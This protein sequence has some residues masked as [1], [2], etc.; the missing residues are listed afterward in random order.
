M[1]AGVVCLTGFVIVV[2]HFEECASATFV[3]KMVREISDDHCKTLSFLIMVIP[4]VSWKEVVIMRT[5]IERTRKKLT[6]S[7][8][9][10]KIA[11]KQ[12]SLQAKPLNQ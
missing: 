2:K 1:Y 11:H 4:F 12:S 6:L 9:K 7:Q 10:A 8:L 3:H 5:K